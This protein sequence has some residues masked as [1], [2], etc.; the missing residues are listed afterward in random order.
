MVDPAL[1]DFYDRRLPEY[2]RVYELPERQ[3]DLD[4]LK[5][6]VKGALTGHRV[7]ELACGTGYWT[8]VAAE[9]AAL[10]LATDASLKA[11]AVART[12]GQPRNVR[13]EQLDAF[14]PDHCSEDFSAVLAGFWLS[15]VSRDRMTAFFGALARGMGEGARAVLMDNRY[16]EGSSTPVSRRD[17]DG[18]TYQLRRLRDGTE[19]ELLKNFL[20]A[21]EL[22]QLAGAV[23]REVEVKELEYYWYLQFTLRAPDDR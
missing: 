9:S 23:G 16:V 8:V 12:R 15:H 21:G 7:L 5:A 14:H 2:D 4:R 10:V 22:E 6:R 17:E 13:F 11:L 1:L 18:N 20:T 3:A 19:Y